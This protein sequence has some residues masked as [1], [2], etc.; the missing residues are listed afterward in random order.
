MTDLISLSDNEQI[1]RFTKA[2]KDSLSAWGLNDATLKLIKYRENAVFEVRN[3]I[4]KTALRVHRP[5]YHSNEAL[6]SEI[7]WM[8]ALDASGIAVPNVIPTTSGALFV[9]LPMGDIKQNLQVDLFEWIGGKQLGS[10]EDGVEDPADIK[11]TYETIGGLAARVHNQSSKWMLPDNFQRHAWDEYGL[12]SESHLWGKFWELEAGSASQTRLLKLC[13]DRLFADLSRLPKSA[14]TFSLIHA[15]IVPE[16][17]MVS[18]D[19]IKLIDFDD[20]GFGWHLFELATS[21]YFIMEK[22]YYEEAKTALFRGYKKHRTLN[23]DV[24]ELLPL[25]FLARGMTYLGWVHTRKS[26]ET[27]IELTPMLLEM[28][29]QLGEQYLLKT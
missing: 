12:A 7:L 9:A 17:L 22:P 1:V 20:A 10:I 25:F 15:D 21:L 6:N 2:A 8:K 14:E 13:K 3:G 16:N 27:A 18:G 11:A 19:Q 26:S 5:G 28:A 23:D 4:T 29:S 24:H